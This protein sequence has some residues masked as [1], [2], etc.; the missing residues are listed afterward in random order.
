MSVLDGCRH[1][2]NETIEALRAQ[3]F[4]MLQDATYL[5]HAGTTLYAKSFIEEFSK[6]MMSSLLGNPHSASASSQLST[7]RVENVRLQVLRLFNAQPEHYDVVFV[8]NAT[9]GIKLVADSLRESRDG[10]WY[11]YHKDAHTSLVGVREVSQTETKCFGSDE[12]VEHW[13][14]G[15]SSC[16]SRPLPEPGIGLFAYPAQSNFNGRRLPLDW[17][18]QIRASNLERH[19]GMYTLLD[20]AALVS[21]S[22]LDLSDASRAPDFTA[23]SFYKMFGFPDLGALIVRKA[24]SKILQSRKYFGGG[25]V[26]MVTCLGEKWHIKKEGAIHEQLE[27]GTLPI[28]SI[29]ALD[30]A[31]NVHKRLFRSLEHISS[32]T[33]FLA[34]QLYEELRALRHDN[35]AS[36]CVMYKDFSSSYADRRSQGPV[37]AFNLRDSRG[38]W[39]SNAEVEKLAVIRKIHLRTGGLCNPGGIASSL[40]LSPWDMKRNFSAGQRCGNENDILEGKPTGII[41]LSLGAM[42]TVQDIHAFLNFVTEFFVDSTPSARLNDA[43]AQIATTFFVESLMIYPIKSCGGWRIPPNVSWGIKPEG[44]AWD[45]EWC[46]IHQGSRTALSQKRYPHMALLR[47]RMDLEA[48]LLRINYTEA[49]P[50]SCPSEI[51]VPL[52]QDPTVFEQVDLACTRS[53]ICGDSIDAQ[54]YSSRVVTDFFTTA[55]GIPCYL[56]RFPSQESGPSARHAKPHLQKQKTGPHEKF[57]VIPNA[58]AAR[59]SLPPPLLFSNESPILIIS[60]SSLNRLNEIIKSKTPAGKAASAQVFRANIIIAED[61]LLPPGTEQPY[62]EDTWRSMTAYPQ[63]SSGQTAQSEAT[64][65]NIIGPCRRCQMVCVDQDTGEKNEEPFITLAKTRRVNGR[66]FFGMHAGLVGGEGTIR[67]GD[68]VQGKG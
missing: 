50:P 58:G 68:K 45:R 13:I 47:P 36:V 18:G 60:R 56:A 17:C 67:V 29:I 52:S 3:E 26:E 14:V 8:A 51:T 44:L 23:L 30:N 11:G 62:A 24:S 53:Q 10:F 64:H 49:L 21:T 33:S 39:V 63:A 7:R 35:G 19:R 15:E 65:L 61:S 37:V 12:E 20:V 55:L 1:S 32:H 16:H 59:T 34:N 27:D 54:V 31:M 2:Y 66:V 4:P 40:C 57:A 25:T 9:A 28:H 38:A 41:R 48:G 43:Q 42:S 22:P 6:D 5:D 46:L